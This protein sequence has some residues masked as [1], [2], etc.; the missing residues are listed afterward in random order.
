[1]S[2]KVKLLRASAGAGKTHRL[3][4]EYI[5]MLLEGDDDSYR[6]ILAVTFT[7]K[8][9]D[10]MKS[11][12]IEELHRMSL[13]TSNPGRAEKARI[14]LI[15]ILND[16]TCFN[17]STIDRFFQTVIRS[18]AREI[19]QYASYKVE[20]DTAGIIS[21][22]VDRM[23]DSLGEEGNEEL[24][25][26]LQD[27]AFRAIEEGGTWN[28]S[29]QL[30]EIAGLFF[31]EEFKLKARRYGKDFGDR[32]AIKAFDSKLNAIINSFRHS[33]KELGE[34]AL[35][36]M[37]ANG[38]TPDM[39][40]GK[41]RGPFMVF[42]RLAAGEIKAPSEKLP[43]SFGDL[44]PGGLEDVVARTMALFREEYRN[45]ASALTIR[46]NL[47]LLGIYS[48]LCRNIE[49]YLRE[50]N[51]LLLNESTD[52][53]ANII[54][55]SDTPF[56]YEKI[57]NRYDHIMLD[58][59][60]DTSLLQWK[61]FMPLFRE[62]ISKGF[63][64]LVVGDIKQSI[65]RWRGSDW[66]LMS[67]YIFE[68]LGPGNIDD[69]EPMNDNWRSG[70]AIVDFNNAVF[71]GVGRGCLLGDVYDDCMQSVPAARKG[72]ES[73]RVKVRFIEE[74][75]WKEEA[76]HRTV[77]DIRELMEKGYAP[78]QITVLVR[79]NEEGA[80]AANALMKEGISVLTEDSLLIGSSECTSA[81]VNILRFL[82]T[83]EDPVCGLLVEDFAGRIPENPADGSLYE[84]CQNLLN[85][86]I[87]AVG[88]KD[89]PFI[90][91]FLDC[92]LDYQG[93]F[94]SSVRGFLR[95]WDES[96]CKKSICAP[97]GQNAVRIMTIHKAK[98]LGLDAVIIPFMEEKFNPR[99]NTVWMDT[100]PP[101]DEIGLIPV[102]AVK[103]L[104]ETVFAEQYEKEMLLGRIDAVNTAYVALTR[105]KQDMVI[106]A[107]AS[108]PSKGGSFTS[109]AGYL[110]ET[111]RERLDGD[112]EYVGGEISSVKDNGSAPEMI[113]Q[114]TFDIIPLGNR[115]KLSLKAE[116][117]FVRGDG[118]RHS[119]IKRH[120]IL[121]RVDRISDL[122]EACAKD[123][124]TFELLSH[125]LACISERHWFD[126]TYTTLNETSIADE[127]GNVF[128]PDR[129]L[130]SAD[131]GR[132][133]VIDYKFGR[134]RD[135][136]KEQVSTYCE[137][138]KRM[139]YRNVEGHIWYVTLN[140]IV[141]V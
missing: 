114:D 3:T 25:G 88:E 112:G 127:Y 138:L 35:S 27:Y 80:F 105:A 64:N 109:F 103:Q 104:K 89:I 97:T 131:G 83:P 125:R 65:Y 60:Q 45:Y 139:G 108:G 54:D 72:N 21:M 128:R 96:G 11:R 75:K 124:E 121:S 78:G 2:E 126:G 119:G 1:M 106:Y 34:E 36:I 26:W 76:I 110:Q 99:T 33:A 53:L 40:K 82:S 71:S 95:W 116:E 87:F 107:P 141:S 16:Y 132:A 29:G 68:D 118:P 111:L 56:V 101:F 133:I 84:I 102:K 14:R 15:K 5:R 46:A 74:K 86:G 129:V 8:A 39:F 30:E 20:L 113:L 115:L 7:N 48:D 17:I 55:G 117:H 41:S 63:G 98:G 137:L 31:R 10:E 18:F 140:K 50:N 93:K 73:G 134:E 32:S 122:K 38:L 62:S 58:E 69:S 24:L 12:I 77:G 23:L 13:D 61:N 120:E 79:K 59:A 37:S 135:S 6:H 81:L 90:H 28:V 100:P 123:T 70:S 44:H 130:V 47:S 136:Y 4:Q 91:A 42:P 92:A 43:D 66:R 22:A 85:A 51:V 49:G 94:G 57:G 67:D 19:G 52:L 9:T